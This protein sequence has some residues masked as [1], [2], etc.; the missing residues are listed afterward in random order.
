MKAVP[1][2]D[3]HPPTRPGCSAVLYAR[4]PSYPII[5]ISA[6]KTPGFNDCTA[7]VSTAATPPSAPFAPAPHAEP[8]YFANAGPALG[9]PA[10]SPPASGSRTPGAVVPRHAHPGASEP[11]P[12]QRAVL[13]AARLMA[14]AALSHWQVGAGEVVEELVEVPK[15]ILGKVLGGKLH[16]IRLIGVSCGFASEGGGIGAGCQG[17]V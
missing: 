12:P 10:P 3:K 9:H 2:C 17:C 7:C 6:S 8:Q 4:V 1:G 11:D 16:H 13:S 15:A 14:C 5:P